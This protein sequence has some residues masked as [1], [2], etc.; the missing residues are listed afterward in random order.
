MDNYNGMSSYVS[1]YLLRN[2]AKRVHYRLSLLKMSSSIDKTMGDESGEKNGTLSSCGVNEKEGYLNI[3]D[4]SVFAWS[5]SG[6][7]TTVVVKRLSDKFTCC[8]DM[9]YA[10]RQNVSCDQVM[11][12]FVFSSHLFT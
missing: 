12:R 2:L 6:I 1:S 10:C 9:G 8:F 3:G 4:F 7:E 5:I 11:I